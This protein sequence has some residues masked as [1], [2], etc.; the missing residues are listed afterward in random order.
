MVKNSSFDLLWES[1]I[2]DFSRVEQAI[3]KFFFYQT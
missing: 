2:L 1:G 3:P